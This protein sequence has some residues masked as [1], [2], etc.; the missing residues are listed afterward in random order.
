MSKSYYVVDESADGERRIRLR[1]EKDTERPC[2]RVETDPK[3]A[4]MFGALTAMEPGELLREAIQ[5]SLAAAYRLGQ[6][7][8]AAGVSKVFRIDYEPGGGE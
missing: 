3:T 4:A 7:D 6:K 5:E 2:E 8:G 1:R